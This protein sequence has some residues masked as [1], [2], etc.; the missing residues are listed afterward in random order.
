M[1]INPLLLLL[2]LLMHDKR[3]LTLMV[4]QRCT[5][6]HRRHGETDELLLLQLI[7]GR[8]CAPVDDYP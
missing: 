6:R 8:R 7:V 2:L 5:V 3:K 4:F 1:H